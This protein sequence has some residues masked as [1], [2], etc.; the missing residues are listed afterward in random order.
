MGTEVAGV[1]HDQNKIKPRLIINSMPRALAAVS[2][3]ATYGANK[4][5]E[6]G[7]VDVPDASKRYADAMYRHLLQHAGGETHDEESGLHHLAHAAWNAL[8]VLELALRGRAELSRT[9]ESKRG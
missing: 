8:A 3:V 6:D 7:W 5:T 2:T 1:K 9:P 4:Y